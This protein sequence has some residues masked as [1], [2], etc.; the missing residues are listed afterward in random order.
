MRGSTASSGVAPFESAG[1]GVT[2]AVGPCPVVAAAVLAL[3]MV[4]GVLGFAA[5]C[6]P[7]VSWAGGGAVSAGGAASSGRADGSRAVRE[8]PSAHSGAGGAVD[9]TIPAGSIADAAGLFAVGPF[10]TAKMPVIKRTPMKVPRV[11]IITF[12][13]E[14]S[15]RTV[16]GIV[17]NTGWDNPEPPR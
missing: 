9:A 16:G 7:R 15:A 4:S 13:R 14:K 6:V 12:D 17:P 5:P 1:D 10:D 8:G 11:A 3:A 2:S